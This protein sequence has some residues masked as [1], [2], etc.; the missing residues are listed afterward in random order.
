MISHVPYKGRHL[1]QALLPRGMRRRYVM[2]LTTIHYWI[3][4][5]LDKHVAKC[6]LQ[7]PLGIFSRGRRATAADPDTLGSLNGLK[8]PAQERIEELRAGMDAKRRGYE[9][10]RANH[11]TIPQ[12]HV[13]APEKAADGLDNLFAQ[14]LVKDRSGR[15][16]KGRNRFLVLEDE[17]FSPVEDENEAHHG[18]SD[19]RQGAS[20]I[21]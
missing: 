12:L 3:L 15:Y 4:S 21:S 5:S 9:E 11:E 20:G 10:G 6:A 13:S 1:D 19:G 17:V 8:K 14:H 18:T 16:G 2:F 7:D